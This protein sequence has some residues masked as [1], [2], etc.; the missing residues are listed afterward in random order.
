MFSKGTSLFYFINAKESIQGKGTQSSAK[1]S[2]WSVKITFILLKCHRSI[3][4]SDAFCFL[5]CHE[6]AH[7]NKEFSREN[8]KPCHES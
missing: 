3:D 6:K 1:F 8:S 4:N 7:D 2:V 5:S